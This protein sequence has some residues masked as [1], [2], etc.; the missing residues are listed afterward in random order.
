[1][2]ATAALHPV[3]PFLAALDCAKVAELAPEIRAM[4]DQDM[5]DIAAGRVQPV[6]HDDVPAW[7]EERA[8]GT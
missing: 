6:P 1:M 4:L 8:R 2:P 7:L 5:A 3:S